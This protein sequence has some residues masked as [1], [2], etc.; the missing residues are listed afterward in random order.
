MPTSDL[1]P[2][3]LLFNS[4]QTKQLAIVVEIDGIDLLTNRPIYT[5]LRYGDPDIFFGDAGLVYGGLRRMVGPRDIIDLDKTEMTLAQMLEPEQ[6][7]ASIS[8]ISLSFVDKNQYM[9]QV[10]SRGILIPDILGAK[11][12]IWIGYTDISYP[13]D[14]VIVYRGVVTG[15]DCLAGSV[16]LQFSDPN[17]KRREDGFITGSSYLSTPIDAVSDVVPV[18]SNADFYQQILGPDGTYDVDGPWDSDT[19]EYDPIATHQTG[20]RTF[21]MIDDEIIEYGPLGF[22]ETPSA[23]LQSLIYTAL[24]LTAGS[25]I[26]SYG[27]NAAAVAGN[28]L[29]V[30]TGQSIVVTIQSG[31]STAAQI[32]A[33]IAA[34]TVEVQSLVFIGSNP[35]ILDITLSYTA[36]G[37]A[38]AEL[39]SVSGHHINVQIQSG[40]STAANIIAAVAAWAPAAA[41]GMFFVNPSN[42][43]TDVQVAPAGLFNVLAPAAAMVGVAVR[44][45]FLGTDVQYSAPNAIVG[46]LV[47]LAVNPLLLDI[48]IAYTPGAVAGFEVVS[49]PSADNIVIQIDGGVSTATQIIAALAAS[50]YAGLLT[51]VVRPGGSGAGHQTAP[52]GPYGVSSAGPLIVGLGFRGCLRGA[53]GTTPA[54]HDIGATVSAAV[55]FTENAMLLALKLMLSGWNGPWKSNLPVFSIVNTGDPV[56]LN[57]PGAI[58]LPFG[59][60][61]IRDYGLTP[62]DP[63]TMAG[64]PNGANNMTS[65]VVRFADLSGQS[66]RI[67]YVENQALVPE[68][69]PPG[70]TLPE[71]LSFRSQYDTYPVSMAVAMTPDDVDVQAHIDLMDS[72]LSDPGDRYQFFISAEESM[73]SFIETEIYAPVSSYSLTRRG[74]LS[75]GMTKPPIVSGGLIVLNNTNVMDPSNIKVS[76]ATNN[77]KFY[78]EID[79]TFDYDI[80]GNYESTFPFINA[81]ALDVIGISSPLPI[82]SRGIKTALGS[83]PLLTK[84][85]IFLLSRYKNGATL[86][87]VKVIWMVAIQIEVGDIVALQDDGLLQITNFQTGTRNLG[88]Q[89][90]E[91]VNRPLAT[92]DG[93]ALLTLISGV[94]I[95]ITDRYGVVSPSS[96]IVSGNTGQLVVQDSYGAKFP[97]N[98]LQKWQNYVGQRINLHDEEYLNQYV[99]TIVSFDPINNYK[100]Y[101]SGFEGPAPVTFAGLIIDIPP[102]PDNTD[103]LEDS[104]YKSIH[105]YFSKAIAIVAGISPTQFTVSAPDALRILPTSLLR[106]SNPDYSVSDL[107]D[108]PI[109]S[110]VGTTVTLKAA[111][112]FTPDSTMILTGIGFPDGN[113]FYRLI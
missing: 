39:V 97:G 101:I 70:G 105:A 84:R 104:I 85:A 77:R 57:Q 3:F 2:N 53:L 102:Y 113:G 90:F 63:V 69:P 8:Q 83:V 11:A 34:P 19:G 23:L 78:N 42:L 74:R 25:P 88:T 50:G 100:M 93:N 33:A 86:I 64:S 16:T 95:E 9:S 1:T 94:G 82:A 13:D 79:W 55:Q 71:V 24:S 67:I 20:V 10:V 92:K 38:G 87:E 48:T 89:L 14:Y 62:G 29:V 21:L 43:G 107:S 7:K 73:K 112:A 68:F 44:P 75:V 54:A 106:I 52:Q 110:V 35:L 72:Y 47:F 37:V 41:L 81:T 98:E 96:V 59:V 99:T 12:R 45:G 65:N 31:V 28:E 15:V 49:N 36:G 32:I 103:K 18:L 111:L 76:R 58:I 51:A 66:N 27:Y 108:F 109:L 60:D 22:V 6:G 5:Y 30:V 91:V 17:V 80:Q 46:D 26:I 40:V 56:L 61:A 4:E